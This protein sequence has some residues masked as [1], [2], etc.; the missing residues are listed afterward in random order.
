ML[1]LLRG[2]ML[3]LGPITSLELSQILML[4]QNIIDQT[5]LK[6]ETT[7]F[8]LRGHFRNTDITQLEWCERRLLARIHRLT[9]DKLRQQIEPVTA[10]QFISWLLNWQ[11]VAPGTQLQW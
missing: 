6:L 7:G 2:W 8:I 11:H 1:N 9:M 4:D 3:H 5:L 10:T